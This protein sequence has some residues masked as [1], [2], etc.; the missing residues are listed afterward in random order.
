MTLTPL[1]DRVLVRRTD[2]DDVSAGGIIIPDSAQEKP[3]EGTIISTGNGLRNSEGNVSPLSVKAGD[4]ILFGKFSGNEITVQ[5]EEL[6]ILREAD[7]MAVLEPV[8]AKKPAAK[9]KAKAK[10]KAKAKAKKK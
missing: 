4:M 9:S 3:A 10:P 6:V 2:S 8:K 5:G 7:I 1:H